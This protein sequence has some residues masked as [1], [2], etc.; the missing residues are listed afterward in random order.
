MEE[1]I[2]IKVKD[3]KKAAELAGGHADVIKALAPEVFEKKLPIEVGSIYKKDNRYW[4]LHYTERP[5]GGLYCYQLTC[6]IDGRYW[7]KTFEN[8][9]DVFDGDEEYFTYIGHASDVLTIKEA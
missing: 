9:E 4:I 8:I 5:A 1:T 2:T 3:L 6:L 7:H